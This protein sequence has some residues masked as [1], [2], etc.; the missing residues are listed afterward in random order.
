[1]PVWKQSLKLILL[2]ILYALAFFYSAVFNNEIGW[3][4]F[5]FMTF[6]LLLCL[7]QLLVPLRGIMVQSPATMITHVGEKVVLPIDLERKQAILPIAQLTVT[8]INPAIDAS[9]STY[10]FYHYQQLTFLWLPEKRGTY[11]ELQLYYQSSDFFN[12]FTKRH[13][14]TLKKKILVL[15][16]KQPLAHTL[17][18]QQTLQNQTF[19]EPTFTIKNY[20]P[21]RS[22]DAPKNIDWKLSS[23]QTTLIYREHENEQTAQMVWIFW[24][25]PSEEFEAMLSLYY[26]LQDLLEEPVE[27]YLFGAHVTD[28]AKPTALAFAQI[29]PLE[30]TPVIPKLTDKMIFF[31]TPKQTPQ[32]TEQ[33]AHL[34]KYNQVAVYDYPGLTKKGSG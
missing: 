26:S 24:G 25:A 32:T 19:G 23:K 21:Y 3:T 27:Q 2:F 31:F 22:G 9:V 20:R 28:P 12:L 11:E 6:I 30:D 13:K 5:L 8:V 17:Q 18:L 16:Q 1:M 7:A 4:L 10:L 14:A 33:V 15:P 29:H 34:R